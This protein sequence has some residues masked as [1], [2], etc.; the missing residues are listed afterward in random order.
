M[1]NTQ[2]YYQ[3]NK[4]AVDERNRKYYYAN[5]DARLLY[6]YAY[7]PITEAERKEKNRLRYWATRGNERNRVNK[8][9]GGKWTPP[10][11][12]LAPPVSFAPSFD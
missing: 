1:E 7:N 4:A 6:Q 5:R 2:T 11:I 8:A 10:W 9:E 12:P 3:R